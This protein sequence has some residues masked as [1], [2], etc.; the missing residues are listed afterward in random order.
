MDGLQH[1]MFALSSCRTVRT[2]Y[3]IPFA[4]M[5]DRPT[6]PATP[7]KESDLEG[8]EPAGGKLRLL[9][10]ERRARLHNRS[11]TIG[12]AQRRAIHAPSVCSPDF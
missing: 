9:R 4:R 8:W 5:T 1:Q 12:A 3:G 10:Q 2:L 7:V 11:K 6:Q